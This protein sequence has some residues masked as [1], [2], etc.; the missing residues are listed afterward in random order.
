MALS[1]EAGWNQVAA[2]WRIFLEL[3]SAV[4]LMRGDGS[5]IATAATLPYDRRFAWISMVLVAAAERRQGL[6]RWLLRHCIDELLARNLVPVLDATPA[7]R[8]VYV[9]LGFRDSW[10]MRRLVGRTIRMP[11]EA[12]ECAAATLRAL[13][14]RDWPQV[15]AYD[16]AIFGADRGALLRRLANRL[17][18]AALVAEHRSR[19]VGFLLGRDGRSMSQLGPLAAEDDRIA[20]ALLAQAIAAVPAPLAIDLP[21]RHAALGDRLAMLG[22]CVERP[23]TRM[24]YGRSIAFDDG[25]R[26]FAVAGPELG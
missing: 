22:F 13:E 17:P 21:D 2:D 11:N 4:G 3:G 26:L 8:A 9:D 1:R 18:A 6:A 10:T 16:T 7:G 12:I 15:I 5:L 23:L 14:A 24:V 19:L 25:A 20:I